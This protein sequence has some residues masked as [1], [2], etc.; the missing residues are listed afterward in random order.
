MEAHS[1]NYYVTD[2]KQDRKEM[3]GMYFCLWHIM[4]NLLLE[5][6]KLLGGH[7]CNIIPKAIMFNLGS[8]V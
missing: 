4:P 5:G 2:Q 1:C 8:L 6:V 3:S 7:I